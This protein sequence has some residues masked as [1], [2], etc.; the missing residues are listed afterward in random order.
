LH[1]C[2]YQIDG[3]RAFFLC[4]EDTVLR[5][6]N[7]ETLANKS[8]EKLVIPYQIAVIESWVHNMT[9]IALEFQATAL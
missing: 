4:T 2:Q 9:N 7:A 3:H 1:S 8:V 5:L 6:M